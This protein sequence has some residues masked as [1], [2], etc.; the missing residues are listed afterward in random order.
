MLLALSFKIVRS[1]IPS[2]TSHCV[3]GEINMT[4]ANQPCYVRMKRIALI[5]AH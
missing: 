1:S 4:E 5:R 3:G 2:R